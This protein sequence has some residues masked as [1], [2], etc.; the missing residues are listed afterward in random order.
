MAGQQGV[1]EQAADDWFVALIRVAARAHDRNDDEAR[2]LVG[3][4]LRKGAT[5]LGG[6]PAGRAPARSGSSAGDV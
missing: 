6:N 2:R 5:G 4:Y 3:V 1:R